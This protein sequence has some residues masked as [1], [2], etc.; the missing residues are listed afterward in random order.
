MKNERKNMNYINGD[1]EV[2]RSIEFNNDEIVF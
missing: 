1:R 2:P